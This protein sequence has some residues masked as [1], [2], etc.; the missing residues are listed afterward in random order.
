M[1]DL[2]SPLFQRGVGARRQCAS[3]EGTVMLTMRGFVMKT[4][5]AFERAQCVSLETLM[6]ISN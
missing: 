1:D 4:Y 3:S 5:S 6:L 2:H